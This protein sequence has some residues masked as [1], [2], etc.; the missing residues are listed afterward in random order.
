MTK[1]TEET[2][3]L[4]CPFCGGEA[5]LIDTTQILGKW[6]VMHRCNAIGHISAEGFD[7]DKTIA[8]W[9]TR[10]TPEPTETEIEAAL[11]AFLE[12]QSAQMGE[13]FDREM[14][15]QFKAE[16]PID[17]DEQIVQMRCAIRAA[18]SVR[19]KGEG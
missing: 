16:L 17:F 1:P 3:L 19:M 2:K 6:R 10:H 13:R 15:A 11:F 8:A 5:K 14:F 18:A 9:N 4:S 7:R 12:E